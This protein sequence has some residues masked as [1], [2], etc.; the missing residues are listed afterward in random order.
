MLASIQPAAANLTQFNGWAQSYTPSLPTIMV[1]T[2]RCPHNRLS[3]S[4]NVAAI[5]P[6]IERPGG[7]RAVDVRSPV[8]DCSTGPFDDAFRVPKTGRFLGIARLC[9]QIDGTSRNTTPHLTVA[10]SCVKKG[11]YLILRKNSR[12]DDKP[13]ALPVLE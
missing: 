1:G 13:G 4:S 10:N 2:S 11:P 8:L 3:C 6:L 12:I 9:Q 5:V 7:S